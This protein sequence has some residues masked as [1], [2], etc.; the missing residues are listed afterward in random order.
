MEIEHPRTKWSFE[1]EHHRTIAVETPASHM[2][3]YQRGLRLNDSFD[4]F[5]GNRHLG[6]KK[7]GFWFGFVPN[8]SSVKDISLLR[9]LQIPS[10]VIIIALKFHLYY[11]M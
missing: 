6:R 4:W 5:Q 11:I 2:T 9:T 10:D 1:W 3:D 7:H 8:K